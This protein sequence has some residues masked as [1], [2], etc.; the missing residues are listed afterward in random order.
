MNP[1][2]FVMKKV[3]QGR[4]AIYMLLL[5]CLIICGARA[6]ET[7]TPA[8][9]NRAASQT[10]PRVVV[11]LG[12]GGARGLAH[13]GVLQAL[14]EAQVPIDLI[15]GT[16]AGSIV[17]ALYA[18]RA[19]AAALRDIFANVKRKDF[20]DFSWLHIL[21]GP[22]TGN[23][24]TSFLETNLQARDFSELKIPFVAVATDYG[25]GEVFPINSGPVAQAV[26]ASAALPPYF[27]AV[28]RDGRRLVDGGVTA[29]LPVNVALKYNPEVVIA[30]N[31]SGALPTKLPTNDVSEV[32]R[33]YSITL[34]VLCNLN[35]QNAQIVISPN[36]GGAKTF[37]VSDPTVLFNAGAQAAKQALPRIKQLLAEKKIGLRET[38]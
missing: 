32:V 28:Q 8:R 14:E 20:V 37:N 10:Q 34:E 23:K 26:H 9:T 2:I 30:V 29:P 11:V 5:T 22:I 33:A 27:R 25:A 16:S 3:S 1:L 19:D 18:D 21:N 17:G 24:L 15:V 13:V 36:V 38:K 7:T 31:V 6:Q 4:Q 35:A 12:S